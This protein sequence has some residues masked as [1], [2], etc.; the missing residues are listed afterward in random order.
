[1]ALRSADPPKPGGGPSPPNAKPAQRG[2]LGSLAHDDEEDRRPAPGKIRLTSEGRAPVLPPSRPPAPPGPPTQ[3]AVNLPGSSA[4]PGAPTVTTANMGG[5][6]AGMGAPTV[7]NAPS[8]PA[9]SHGGGSLA[10]EP[11]GE[12]TVMLA[13]PEIPKDDG[14]STRMLSGPLPG[15]HFATPSG[16]GNNESTTIGSVEQFANLPGMVKPGAASTAPPKSKLKPIAEIKAKHKVKIAPTD[17]QRQMFQQE[18][19]ERRANE[20]SGFLA[21]VKEASGLFKLSGHE[22]PADAPSEGTMVG[23]FLGFAAFAEGGA[24]PLKD[25]TADTK[26]AV[27][28]APILA[29]LNP[30]FVMDAIKIGDIKLVDLGRDHL[31]EIQGRALLVLDG[32]VALARFSPQVLAS[33]KAAQAA[34]VKGDKYAEKRE[35]NRR[36][37]VGPII[38]LAES[39]LG[40]FT[41]GDL[42]SLDLA[43]PNQVGLGV[44]SVTP[45]RALSI[46]LTRLDTWRRTY[47]FFAE[48]IRRA[49]DAARSRLDAS[50]GARGMIA[51]F[52]IRHGFSVGMSLRV[53]ILSKCIECYE[54]EKACEKRYGVKRLSLGGKVLG[55]LDFVDCCRTCIDQRCVDVC[56]YDSI[57]FDTEKGEVVISEDLCTGCGMCS[58]ACPY[59]AIEMQ[60]LDE[61]PLLLLRLQKEKKLDWGDNKPRKAKPRRVASKCDHCAS[62]EDQ[63]C[64]SACPTD[65]IVEMSPDVAFVDRTLEQ[66]EAAKGGYERSAFFKP[67][68]LFDPKKFF[69]GLSEADDNARATDKKQGGV[70]WTIAW[71]IGFIGFFLCLGE[72]LLRRYEDLRTL[73]F[74][75]WY[76]RRFVFPGPDEVDMALNQVGYRPYDQL[77][78]WLAYIGSTLMFSSMFYS[79]RKW[80]P[81]I[82]KLGAQRGWFNYH[83]WSGAVGP[84]L[85]LLHS[86]GRL[87]N[88]VSIAIWAMV[89]AV[90][91]GLVGRFITTVMPERAS[92]AELRMADLERKLTDLRNRHGG[93]SVADRFYQSLRQRYARVADPKMHGFVAG[94]LALYIYLRDVLVRPFRSTLL[95]ARL[96]GIKD[97]AARSQVASVA[98]EMAEIECRRVLLPRIEPLFREWK[99]IHIPFAII[100]TIVGGIHIFIEAKKLL[101]GAM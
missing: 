42:L 97:P 10:N 58:L 87:D 62:F 1:M 47:H 88:W 91:S 4:P 34:Y 76:Q 57:K 35:Y 3:P 21:K 11:Q 30:Q 17:P 66:S 100:L 69:Q 14:E 99:L 16:G 65:A 23:Q 60:E 44:Y 80:V 56:G 68:E 72:I 78:L 55:G 81:G 93:V 25:P 94:G 73:S 41:E 8:L 45:V 24:G 90:L 83:V 20:N 5:P 46:S 82:K 67:G 27:E 36:Q 96:T 12:A 39:N 40:L 38:R 31:I 52:F 26:E 63:A 51:D 32:Q 95:R 53:R 79:A 18:A 7:R 19:A 9:P 75:F 54:C 43:G 89:A 6:A 92:R 77:G 22:P 70:L 85:V 49:V 28:H 59:D 101:G 61:K 37:E 98:T 33:E 13:R 71:I 74:D 2:S 84:M 29:G 15:M 64:I 50:T 86:A 48:R